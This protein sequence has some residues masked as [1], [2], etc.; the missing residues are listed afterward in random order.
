[1]NPETHDYEAEI[2]AARGFLAKCSCCPHTCEADRTSGITGYCRSKDDFPVAAIVP[3]HGEEPCI[4]GEYGICNVFFAS[5]NL[6]CVYCQNHQISRSSGS[7][8]AG[9]EEV[10]E[11]IEKCLQQGCHAVGFVS[12]SHVI[13]QVIQLITL[14]K[15]RGN[16]PVFVYNSNA[17]DEVTMLR[18]L[19]G[20]IDVYLPDFKYI[21]GEI[22]GRY[23]GCPDYPGKAAAA[24][25]EMYRQK[26]STLITD[27]HGQARSGLIIRHL[28]LPSHSEHSIAVLRHIAE[29]L[30]VNIHISLMAQYY[31]D[32]EAHQFPEINRTLTHPEYQSVVS[33]FERLGFRKGWIQDLSSQENYRPD[34]QKDL[35]F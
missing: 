29:E 34:F 21:D 17:Y 31:P 1:M 33:E 16:N 22:A 20:M 32:A 11:T 4:S 13:P 6:Q 2:Q 27:A 8:F 3:H 23:S 15:K 19:E 28:V 9:V 24:I 10:I 18:R 12:P 7:R 30:S 25:K 26:G 35:P 5:C 14:L